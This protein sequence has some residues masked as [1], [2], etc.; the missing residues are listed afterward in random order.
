MRDPTRK[1]ERTKEVSIF[2]LRLPG[3]DRWINRVL[4][5]TANVGDIRLGIYRIEEILPVRAMRETATSEKLVWKV[6][7]N[8]WYSTYPL[9]SRCRQ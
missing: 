9:L 4:I 5:A 7:R 8:F 6:S 3:E 2:K 1:F